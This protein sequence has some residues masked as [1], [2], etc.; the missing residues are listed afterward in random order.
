MLHLVAIHRVMAARSR[1][2]H[3]YAI[4]VELIRISDSRRI[5]SN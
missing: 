2:I 5:A 4:T 1:S 3:V